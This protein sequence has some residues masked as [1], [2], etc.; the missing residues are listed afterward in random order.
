MKFRIES[1]TEYGV[2][3]FT[4]GAETYRVSADPSTDAGALSMLAAATL[5][6]GEESKAHIAGAI[7]AIRDGASC[8]GPSVA[9]L[10]ARIT[11][12]TYESE[13]PNAP[14]PI[15]QT[16]ADIEPKPVTWLWEGRIP[17]GRISLLVGRPG[18]GKSFMTM[19]LAARVSTGSPWPDQL[20][21]EAADV[22]LLTGEDDAAEVIRPRL[23]AHRADTT[24]IHI[25]KGFNIPAGDNGTRTD[26][27]L[28]LSDINP[29]DRMLELFPETRLM[30]VDPIGSFLAGKT[31]AH[32]DNEVRA[33]LAPFAR[34]CEDRHC[35]ALLVAH[36]RKSGA[37]FADDMVLGS[38]AFTGIARTVWH[39]SADPENEDRR[40]LL[41]GKNNLAKRGSGFAFTIGGE[42]PRL[43]WE[44][45]PVLLSADA[46]LRAEQSVDH[47]R[48]GPA[49]VKRTAAAEFLIY[50]LK[51]GPKRVSEIQEAAE[52]AGMIFRTIRVAADELGIIP[53]RVG[54]GG[55]FTWELPQ[56]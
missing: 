20:P 3:N 33:V 4:D 51:N 22:L 49:P 8:Y 19:D 46:G 1:T 34:I 44:A 27:Y 43:W 32:R 14:R 13:N 24:R 53:K 56:T 9:G 35:A 38:R 40:L 12:D 45:D 47:A 28:T 25:L 21:C 2:W 11:Q 55:G 36:R 6:F 23:D 39:L 7:T 15:Y 52:S 42:P 30:I 41:P 16:L 31:D 10:R 54:F 5:H 29:I 48:R 26:C 18:E 37:D 50:E 17:A